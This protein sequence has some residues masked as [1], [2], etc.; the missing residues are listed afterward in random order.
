MADNEKTGEPQPAAYDGT[1][2][3]NADNANIHPPH[4]GM[5]VG[6]YLATRVSSLK[7]AMAPAPNPI[8]LVLMLNRHQWAF[9]FVAFFAWVRSHLPSP[10]FVSAIEHQADPDSVP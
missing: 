1:G 5:S 8:R 2:E 9:F 4:H 10:P 6:K 3:F 7:P